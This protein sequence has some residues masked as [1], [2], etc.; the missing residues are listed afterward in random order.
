MYRGPEKIQPLYC[1]SPFFLH[2][3]EFLEWAMLGS[4]QRPLRCEGSA[5]PKVT[6]GTRAGVDAIDKNQGMSSDLP[7]AATGEKA[8]TTP[9]RAMRHLNPELVNSTRVS[10]TS[11]LSSGN[12]TQ[13]NSLGRL[14]DEEALGPL[15]YNEGGRLSPSNLLLCLPRYLLRL[16]QPY[17]NR[18]SIG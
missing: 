16:L 4:N 9:E 3:A 2:I 7:Y 14:S 6:V 5:P 15:L 12:A 1:V 11:Q 18:A 8:G 10:E 17:C 13:N